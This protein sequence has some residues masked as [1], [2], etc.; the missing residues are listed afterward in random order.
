MNTSIMHV[1]ES[2]A[3]FLMAVL[4][5]VLLIAVYLLPWLVAHFRKVRHE[6]SIAVVNVLLGFTVIGWIVALAMAASSNRRELVKQ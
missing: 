4:W 2:S 3:F 5:A 6:G 1:A